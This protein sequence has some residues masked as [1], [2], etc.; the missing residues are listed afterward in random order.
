MCNEVLKLNRKKTNNPT[1]K[2]ENQLNEHFTKEG[3]W[4]ANRCMKTC[5]PSSVTTKM[6]IE[7]A[8]RYHYIPKRMAEI[9]KT[10]PSKS[11]QGCG[12]AAG[13]M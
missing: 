13:G 6:H 11:G 3:V 12:G 5:S 2:W 8:M 10:D 7:T 1:Q 4:M 9:R